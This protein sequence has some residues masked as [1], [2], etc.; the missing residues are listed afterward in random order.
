MVHFRIVNIDFVV[1]DAISMKPIN[2]TTFVFFLTCKTLHGTDRI[3]R[4]SNANIEHH[5]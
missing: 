1:F 4:L 5:K 3:D 2:S